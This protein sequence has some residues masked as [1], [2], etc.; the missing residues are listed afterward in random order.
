L[1][2][3]EA[4]EEKMHMQLVI[5][6]KFAQIRPGGGIWSYST[7]VAILGRRLARIVRKQ[8]SFGSA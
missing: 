7:R 3:E 4:E 5:Q 2:R 6:P 8:M 1:Q